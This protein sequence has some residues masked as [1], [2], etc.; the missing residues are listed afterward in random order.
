MA[1]RWIEIDHVTI[2]LYH[3]ADVDKCYFAREYVSG[4]GYSASEA[5]QLILN[6][7]K[8]RD[9]SHLPE[10]KYKAQAI[11]QF[12]AEL[13]DFL[14]RGATVAAMPTSKCR[15]DLDYDD[16]LIQTL[17]A[18]AARRADITCADLLTVKRSLNPA[19][20]GGPRGP[21]TLLQNLLWIGPTDPLPMIMLVDDVIGSGG[22]FRAC[23]QAVLEHWPQ[24]QVMGAFWARAVD[25][26]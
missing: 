12:A 14:P 9:R 21:G 16:R 7:K 17:T 20:S 13:A 19:H 10:Y 25:E 23:K 4:G 5:N 26:Q 18:V 11:A 15:D 3:L 22:H 6:F 1:P 24:C 2:Q 8:P